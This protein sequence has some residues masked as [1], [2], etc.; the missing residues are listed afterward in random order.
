[1]NRGEEGETEVSPII[2]EILMVTLV[3]LAATVEYVFLF[4]FPTLEAGGPDS[5]CDDNREIATHLIEARMYMTQ[6]SLIFGHVPVYYIQPDLT[7]ILDQETRGTLRG[8]MKL[9]T[10]RSFLLSCKCSGPAL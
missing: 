10:Q 9:Q 1:M 4:Q 3:C 6:S 7:M 8:H 2:A 5:S